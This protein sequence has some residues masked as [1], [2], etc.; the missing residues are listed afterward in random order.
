M[1]LF[2][3]L[4]LPQNTSSSFHGHCGADSI[5]SKARDADGSSLFKV[6]FF[7]Q[8]VNSVMRF[9]I[10]LGVALR[11]RPGSE[12]HLSCKQIQSLQQLLLSQPH[13]S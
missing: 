5:S 13:L 8:S 1:L 7:W 9:Q 12:R 2:Q 4:H 3:L 10:K 11:D 6:Q